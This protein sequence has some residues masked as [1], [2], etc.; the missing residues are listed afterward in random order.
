PEEEKKGESITNR[1]KD[2]FSNIFE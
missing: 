2:F 1:V